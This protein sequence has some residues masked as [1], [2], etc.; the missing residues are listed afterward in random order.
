MNL[1]FSLFPLPR[2]ISHSLRLFLHHFDP[3]TTVN[4]PI[5]DAA[6]Q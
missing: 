6:S 1:D 2:I 4:G 3:F 5:P